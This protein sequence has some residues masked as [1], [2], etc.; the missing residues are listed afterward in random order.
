M[1]LVSWVDG[2]H[3]RGKAML[4]R[5][6]HHARSLSVHVDKLCVDER[7]SVLVCHGFGIQVKYCHKWR[8]L[9]LVHSPVC[10]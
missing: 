3:A 1:V 7:D 9:I 5:G 10:N 6:T 2:H 4:M 8:Y